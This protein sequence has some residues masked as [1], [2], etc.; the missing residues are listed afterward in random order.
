M[1]DNGLTL[2]TALHDLGTLAVACDAGIMLAGG[3]VDMELDSRLLAS[4]AQ[5]PQAFE[6]QTIDRLSAAGD[7]FAAQRLG[8]ALRGNPR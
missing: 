4:A 6:R 3:N 8:R 1:V 5:D 7:L 2:I